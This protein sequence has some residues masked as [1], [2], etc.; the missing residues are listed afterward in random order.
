VTASSWLGLG[1][2]GSIT[3]GKIADLVAVGGDPRT[4]TMSLTDVRMVWRSGRLV[5]NA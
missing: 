1:D 3:S 4:S 5:S 2:R